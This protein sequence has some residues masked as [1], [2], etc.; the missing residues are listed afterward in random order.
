MSEDKCPKGQTVTA[1]WFR[2]IGRGPEVLLEIDRKWVMV[3]ISNSP[4]PMSHILEL[5]SDRKMPPD[6]DVDSKGESK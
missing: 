5:H 6:W 2:N 4:W 1:V 3:D